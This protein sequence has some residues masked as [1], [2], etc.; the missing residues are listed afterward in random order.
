[1]PVWTPGYY[2]IMDYPQE[3]RDFRA[4]DDSGGALP[5]EKTTKS[6]RPAPDIYEQDPQFLFIRNENRLAGGH[7]LQ[8]DVI[9]SRPVRRQQRTIFSGGGHRSR[10]DVN[11]GLEAHPGHAQGLHDPVLLV[12]DEPLAL[13]RL[14]ILLSDHPEEPVSVSSR[15][16]LLRPRLA[17]R[18][19][20][21]ARLS[22]LLCPRLSLWHLR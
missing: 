14:E 22:L 13:K 5:W 9:D 16:F 7:L 15:I 21:E 19:S 2:R 18:D 3:R 10:D 20:I 4:E 12:D 6:V 8:H 1:M 17:L 11:L